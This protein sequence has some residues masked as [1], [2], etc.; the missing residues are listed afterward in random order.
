MAI[1]GGDFNAHEDTE[2]VRRVTD[3]WVDLFRQ[4]QPGADGT[5]YQLSWP[6]GSPMLRFRLDYLFL[7]PGRQQWDVLEASHVGSEELP[8]SDHRAVVARVT[9][10]TTDRQH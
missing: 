8:H 6:W 5:T 7:Q 4:A 1:I 3:A 9:P 2:R 10:R